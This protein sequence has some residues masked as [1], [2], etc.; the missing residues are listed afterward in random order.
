MV[1]KFWRTY[2]KMERS[3]QGAWA[4]IKTP[5]WNVLRYIHSP[6]LF[7]LLLSNL[8][9]PITGHALEAGWFLLRHAIRHSDHTLRQTAVEKFVLLPFHSGWDQ[10]H[11]GLFSFQ[12]VD[13]HCPT[14]VKMKFERRAH[15]PRRAHYP[16]LAPIA[17]RLM[18]M[19][20]EA[21][22]LKKRLN[23]QMKYI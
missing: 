4:G 9:F 8:S 6:K 22:K 10:D 15:H 16:K 11:G 23:T 3:F 2:L 18:L 14:Q 7:I 13:G 21:L 19:Y 17:N 20:G 1:R 5:V 12:D